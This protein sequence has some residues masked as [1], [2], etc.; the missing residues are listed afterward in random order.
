MNI[1]CAPSLDLEFNRRIAIKDITG[2][3]GG[4]LHVDCMLQHILL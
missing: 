1:M 3:T 4:T 2:T